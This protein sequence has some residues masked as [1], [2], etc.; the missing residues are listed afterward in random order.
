MNLL[1]S[2]KAVISNDRLFSPE[3]RLLLAVSGGLDSVVLCELCYQAGYD[4]VMVHCNFGL[5][6]E[7]SVRDEDFVKSLAPRYGK[8]VLVKLFATE[9]Y[10]AQHKLSIQEAARDLRYRWFFELIG[11]KPAPG[12]ILTAHHAND[13]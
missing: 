5:R 7:E 3:S 12:Y 9:Q 8:P 11:E 10:A 6:G 1:S 13:N 4:F 2:F